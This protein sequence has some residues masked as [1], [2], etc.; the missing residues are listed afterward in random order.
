MSS[1]LQTKSVFY[2]GFVVS[3]TNY[4]LDFDEAGAGP[5]YAELNVG[6]YTLEA[7]A[8]EIQ[9]AMNATLSIANT[10]T[11][12][13]DRDTRA[14]TIAGSGNFD[15]LI[16]SG[17]HSATSVFSL[18][19]FTGADVT[20]V[21][22]STGS[23]S[24]SEYLPQFP[25]QKY[26]DPTIFKSPVSSSVN[27][28]ANGEVLEIVSFGKVGFIEFNIRYATDI[29]QGPDG[30]I[31]NNATGVADLI[32]FMDAI[33]NGQ[34]IEFMKDRSTRSQKFDILIESTRQSKDGVGFK[35]KE[36]GNV[37]GYYETGT[38]KFRDLT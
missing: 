18:A 10:Y 15:L 19:G 23:S 12:T 33:T 29:A 5:Y 1:L 2:Y 36:L 9:R 14:I 4:Q 31:Q 26:I 28:S 17:S 16:T 32:S 21:T 27:R 24:G 8:T 20:S 3:S 6:S 34:T 35:L 30:P 22:T 11:V 38:L 37:P 25:L 13:A 7:F